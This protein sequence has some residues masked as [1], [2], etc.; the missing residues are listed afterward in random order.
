MAE[1]WMFCSAKGGVGKSFV[2]TNLGI[3]L[4][5]LRKKVLVVDL[6]YTSGNTHSFFGM[7]TPA[8]GLSEFFENKTDLKSLIHTTPFQ[9]CDLIPSTNRITT[10]FTADYKVTAQLISD[11]RAFDYDFV[12]IDTPTYAFA[13]QFNLMN[14]V[15]KTF[16]VTTPETVSVEKTYRWFDLCVEKKVDLD[17]VGLIV[18]SCRTAQQTTVG[19]SINSSIAKKYG[20][21]CVQIAHLPFDNCVWQAGLTHQCLYKTFPSSS[22]G[23]EIYRF[24]KQFIDSEQVRAVS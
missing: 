11:L 24:S 7:P 13:S 14:M 10:E 6:D 3:S 5:K 22:I 16:M 4:S 1:I 20:V 18:N 17:S 9:N 23:H 2:S 21:N 19:F 15:D 12:F 8:R